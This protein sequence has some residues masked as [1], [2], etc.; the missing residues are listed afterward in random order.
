MEVSGRNQASATVANFCD[1]CLLLNKNVNAEQ[2][3]VDCDEFFCSSCSSVHKVSKLSRNHK[4]LPRE[5]MPLQK[6]ASTEENVCSKHSKERLNY[7]C[8]VHND[9]ACTLCISLEHKNCSIQYIDEIAT[10]FGNSSEFTSLTERISSLVQKLDGIKRI[11]ARDS[12]AL[13]TMYNQFVSDVKSFRSEVNIL[14]DSMEATI[15]KE[16]QDVREINRKAAQTVSTMCHTVTID[17][18][19]IVTKL[20]QHKQYKQQRQL[21]IS[22]KKAEHKV[23]EYERKMNDVSSQNMNKNYKLHKNLKVLQAIKSMYSLDVLA[24]KDKEARDA[25]KKK[26]KQEETKRVYSDPGSLRAYYGG[27]INVKHLADTDFCWIKS[28][29]MIDSHRI[30][31]TDG[32]NHA[33]KI[34]NVDSRCILSYL[35][36]PAEPAGVACI[37]ESE[38]VVTCDD[39][40]AFVNV[41]QALTLSKEI[42]V[43][44]QCKDVIVNDGELFVSFSIPEPVIKLMSITGE[45]LKTFSTDKNGQPLF[46]CPW[47]ICLSRDRH[48]LFVSDL[49][50]NTVTSMDLDGDD[51]IVYRNYDSRYLFGVTSD[52]YGNVYAANISGTIYQISSHNGGM[53]TL[54]TKT[55]RLEYAQSLTYCDKADRLYISHQGPKCN[56]LT[57]YQLQY[58]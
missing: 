11:S 41:G 44:G 31:V 25:M 45:I 8:K 2:Y 15:L 27:D 6:I 56:V 12:E 29:E 37:S 21:V 17:L 39:T 4:I 53:R 49:Q 28:G 3:C 46:K 24:N 55:K 9:L 26:T 22:T 30:A 43:Y 38:L 33:L 47:Y 57:V 5:Q 18:N 10:D 23:R 42:P 34:I 7:F 16:A 51:H 58:H 19:E 14:L 20:E 32:K 48:R 13:Q 52:R 50:A 36:L 54:L 1:P 40:L 35:K